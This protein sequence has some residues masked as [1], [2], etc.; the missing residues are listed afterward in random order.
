MIECMRMYENVTLGFSEHL[1]SPLPLRT[2]LLAALKES[3]G[4]SLFP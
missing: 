4:V 2:T 1:Q 3:L